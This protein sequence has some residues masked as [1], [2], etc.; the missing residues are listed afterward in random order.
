MQAKALSTDAIHLPTLAAMTAG[1]GVTSFAATTALTGTLA[2]Y[3]GGAGDVLFTLADLCL[4]PFRGEEAMAGGMGE[5]EGGH[6]THRALA[7]LATGGALAALFSREIAVRAFGRAPAFD[8]APVYEAMARLGHV[9]EVSPEALERLFEEIFARAPDRAYLT[10]TYHDPQLFTGPQPDLRRRP[11]AHRHMTM[12]AALR[13]ASHRGEMRDA[14]VAEIAVLADR[15]GMEDDSVRRIFAR[16]MGVPVEP[17]PGA[18]ERAARATGRMAKAGA[19][20]GARA[21]AEAGI[22]LAWQTARG[23]RNG[24]AYG[25]PRLRAAARRMA[26]RRRSALPERAFPTA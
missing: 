21:G 14:A 2:T 13:V 9:A 19:R 10:A 5:M 18:A 11:A 16:M 15:L 17:G 23:L 25:A 3:L 26:D 4:T 7:L 20:A 12:V 6:G 1:L 24:V 8:D 22:W